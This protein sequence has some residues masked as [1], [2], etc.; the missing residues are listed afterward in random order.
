LNAAI[1][2]IDSRRRLER[3]RDDEQAKQPLFFSQ[4][5]VGPAEEE[6]NS[7]SGWHS[8]APNWIIKGRDKQQSGTD[9]RRA[10]DIAGQ[11][12]FQ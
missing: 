6:E 4:E 9:S 5:T 11:A 2:D 3:D 7:D 12:T 10:M 1:S 8:D